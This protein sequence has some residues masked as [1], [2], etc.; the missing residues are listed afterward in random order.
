MKDHDWSLNL[1][2]EDYADNPE[3]ILEESAEAVRGTKEGCCVNL[4]TP[5]TCGDPR[6]G[7]M[8]RLEERFRREGI[9]FKEIRYVDQCGCGGHVTRVFR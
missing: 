5:G 2:G 7:L 6:D 8:S 4:V 9:A 1:E 3:R